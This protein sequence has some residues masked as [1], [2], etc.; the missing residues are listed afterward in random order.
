MQL[1][2]FTTIMQYTNQ[3]KDK[4]NKRN[5]MFN[6]VPFNTSRLEMTENKSPGT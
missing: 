2:H 6:I 5:D 1:S 3:S 4:K